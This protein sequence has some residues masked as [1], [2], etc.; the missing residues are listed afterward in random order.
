MS[1]TLKILEPKMTIRK[2]E[3]TKQPDP[4]SFMTEVFK[5]V[6]SLM[7]T[8]VAV[9]IKKGFSR[10]PNVGRWPGI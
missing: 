4:E 10:T 7:E 2:I 9:A 3:V 1:E 5:S 6:L 8:G